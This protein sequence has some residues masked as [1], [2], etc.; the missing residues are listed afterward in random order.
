MA[1]FR[2]KRTSEGQVTQSSSES[3]IAQGHIQTDF[4]KHHG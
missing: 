1:S 3:C 2:L 4:K